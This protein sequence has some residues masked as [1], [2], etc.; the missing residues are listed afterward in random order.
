MHKMSKSNIN[1]II[2]HN[3]NNIELSIKRYINY[4]Y[5]IN[6]I[7]DKEIYTYYIDLKIYKDRLIKIKIK[8]FFS[9]IYV[10][11]NVGMLMVIKIKKI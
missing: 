11:K 9:P 2:I 6:I 10:K 5:N 1:N 7:N 3:Q 8:L 4:I